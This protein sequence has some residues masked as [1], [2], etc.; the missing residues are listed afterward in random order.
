MVQQ[1]FVTHPL[2]L[3]AL[4]TVIVAAIA[5]GARYM[6]SDTIVV[7]RTSAKGGEGNAMGEKI[8]HNECPSCGYDYFY[9]GERMGVLYCASDNCRA[10][11]LVT[12]Y[13]PGKIWAEPTGDSG[14][15]YLYRDSPPKRSHP[16]GKRRVAK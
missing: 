3:L 9:T 14:P 12:N 11:F 5:V 15:D 16:G 10:G 4:V 13:G 1:F 8:A 7:P 6:K 2:A